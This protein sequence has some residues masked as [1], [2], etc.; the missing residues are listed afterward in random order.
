M[1]DNRMPTAL[2]F[3]YVKMPFDLQTY[4]RSDE[5]GL[6]VIQTCE[7][8]F[9]R[10]L[11]RTLKCH[12]VKCHQVK[13]PP[14]SKE[15]SMPQKLKIVTEKIQVL[16]LNITVGIWITDSS[17]IKR[18]IWNPVTI[19][20]PDSS[21]IQAFKLKYSNHLNTKH[22]NTRQ[23]GM[24]AIEMVIMWL[25][26]PFEY[27]IKNWDF[28]LGQPNSGSHL[29]KMFQNRNWGQPSKIWMCWVVL[30]IWYPLYFIQFFYGGN[31]ETACT[32]FMNCNSTSSTRPSCTKCL[33]TLSNSYNLHKVWC[34]SFELL[35]R[36]SLICAALFPWCYVPMMGLYS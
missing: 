16:I 7:P 20:I 34:N 5:F 18:S 28:G 33:L 10:T 30:G 11:F 35:P 23:Y 17:G 25:S 26:G 19:W 36:Y 29:V 9:F 27:Q 32:E 3:F 2:D 4:L 15:I 31:E 6:S 12:Q 22:L 13:H 8:Y 14:G 1:S 24:S 21:G